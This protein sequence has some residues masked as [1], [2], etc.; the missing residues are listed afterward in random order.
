WFF[1]SHH[2]GTI[3]RGKSPDYLVARH[4]SRPNGDVYDELTG[5]STIWLRRI[6]IEVP[7]TA[8]SDPVEVLLEF[9]IDL[10]GGSTWATRLASYEDDSLWDRVFRCNPRGMHGRIRARR[11]GRGCR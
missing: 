4:E 6:G 7:R 11:A 2:L 9:P 5:R 1:W 8:W 10:I 3:Q